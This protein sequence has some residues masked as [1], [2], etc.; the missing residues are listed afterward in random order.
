MALVDKVHPH[1]VM[2]GQ[3][4]ISGDGTRVDDVKERPGLVE[5]SAIRAI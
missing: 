2:P 3:D 5:A 4:A 1:D